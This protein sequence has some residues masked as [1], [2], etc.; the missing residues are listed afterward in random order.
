MNHCYWHHGVEIGYFK[1]FFACLLTFEDWVLLH[2]PGWTGTC[3]P[4]D[5][6]SQGLDYRHTPPCPTSRILN[7]KEDPAIQLL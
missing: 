6:V 5:T 4:P 7:F 1:E 3:D 2:S